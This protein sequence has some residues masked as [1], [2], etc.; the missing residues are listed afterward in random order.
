MS[1]H[2]SFN[3]VV[4]DV[5][6]DGY[7]GLLRK[8]P[9]YDRWNSKLSG[10]FARWLESE[11][12]GQLWESI[13]GGGEK[14]G[15]SREACFY[16]I[17][18]SAAE[19]LFAGDPVNSANR[20][21]SRKR[22]ESDY[23]LHLAKCAEALSKHHRR[24]VEIYGPNPRSD[25]LAPWFDEEAEK[26]RRLSKLVISYSTI[27]RQSRGRKFAREHLLFM[28]SLVNS[29]ERNFGKPYYKAVE[30]ITNIAYPQ[31]GD[32]TYEDVRSACR[33]LRRV[34]R[35]PNP[36]NAE[37]EIF[38]KAIKQFIEEL[39]TTKGKLSAK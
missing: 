25:A 5:I 3:D 13:A 27:G 23:F 4:K 12:D 24:T 39:R 29:M 26:F 2:P 6:A 22:A 16:R 19:A 30:A 8:E 20:S 14:A 1:K 36:S 7:D 31:I 34:N 17:A 18:I 11:T 10:F 37:A 9:G 33:G 15:V 38:T 28:R 21:P 32:I 35:V